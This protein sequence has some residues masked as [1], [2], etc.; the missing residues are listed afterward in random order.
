MLAFV[1]ILQRGKEKGTRT[2]RSEHTGLHRR[3]DRRNARKLAVEITRICCARNDRDHGRRDPFMINIIPVDIL[4]ESLAH[5]LLGVGG[6][7]PK[8]LVRIARQKLL[9]DGD[10]IAGHVDRVQGLVGEN[11]VVDL[12]LVFAAEGR[13]LEE[14]LVDQ[15]A[16]GPPVDCAA[17]FLVEQDLETLV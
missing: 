16:E 15:D 3:Q 8:T 13:L 5:D 2:K 9:Q 11:G 1:P 4:E 12:V 7:R 14:H 10:R 6:T 17:V